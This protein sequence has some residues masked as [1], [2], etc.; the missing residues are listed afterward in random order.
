MTVS[1]EKGY[2]KETGNLLFHFA[3]LAL[4][5][6]V[7]YGSWFGWHG[8]R[9]LVAG[10]DGFCNVVTQLDDLQPR[11]AGRTAATWSRSA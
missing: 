8:G 11:G 1:A 3:L 5:I 6:G 9:L 2:I 4:L 7:A 10:N